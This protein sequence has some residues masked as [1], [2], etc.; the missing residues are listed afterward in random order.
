MV[1]CIALD[2][3]W[4]GGGPCPPLYSLGDRITD[5]LAKYELRSPTEYYS[6]SFLL[7][8]LVLLVSE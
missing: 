4:F 3:D 6:G 2:V 8:R 1:V 5:I 7:F